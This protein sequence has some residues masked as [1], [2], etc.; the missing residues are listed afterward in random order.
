MAR[1]DFLWI[2][3]AD[4]LADPGFLAEV[5]AAFERPDVVMSYCQSRQIDAGGHVLARDYLDYLSDVDPE[6]WKQ[7]YLAAGP[8]EVRR[9]LFLKNTIPNVSA[10]VFRRDALLRVLER[11]A[12][13]ITSFRHTGDWL[14]YVRLLESG[15]LA[16]S[17]RSL[18]SH[19][20]HPSSVT[21]G[22]F[23][24]RHLQEVMQV[25]RDT[26]ARYNL[27]APSRDRADRYAQ[28]LYEQFGLATDEYP[29]ID[30]RLELKD[31]VCTER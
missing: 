16:F 26:I 13:E 9:A 14:A 24:L 30:T 19:R 25:Q 28:R 11:C 23:G 1:G 2:A 4:D 20:R 3:E 31:L 6:H 8:E 17:P 10:V 18:N 22:N 27:G 21:V 15:S 29:T 12:D 7:S 5:L